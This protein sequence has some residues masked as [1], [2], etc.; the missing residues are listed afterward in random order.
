MSSSELIHRASLIRLLLTDC[1][2]VLTDGTLPYLV[3]GD[4]VS[5]DSKVFHIHDGLGLKLAREAGLKTGI[6][7]GRNSPA[8]TARAHELKVDYLFQGNDDK[9][10]IY[11][12]ILLAE[13][14]RDEQVAYIGDDLPDLPLLLRVGLALAPADAVSEVRACAHL[15]TQRCGG[16]G[17][18]RE[19]IEFILKAQDKQ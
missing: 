19:A 13:N 10:N 18:V 17:V 5:C 7:S 14:L 15:I 6:I 12:Q 11:E 9:L 8:L 2:G 16:R 3:S 4:Q 1:D